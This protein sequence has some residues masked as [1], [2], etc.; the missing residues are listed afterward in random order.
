MVSQAD[1]DRLRQ[2]QA[3][4]R[5]LVERDLRAYLSTLDMS[6]VQIVRSRLL[7]FVPDLVETYGESAAAMAQDWY[8]NVRDDL[9]LPR[10]FR[11]VVPGKGFW[12]EAREATEGTVRRVAGMAEDGAQSQMATALSSKAGKYAVNASRETIVRSSNEDP[13]ASGW[14]R[15]TRG[16]TCRFCRMLAGRGAVC[17]DDTVR[18]AAHGGC[19]CA[20]VPSWDKNAPE[21]D[22]DLYKASAR[23]DGIRQSAAAGDEY[24]IREL[25]R[26]RALIDRAINEYT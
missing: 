24:A 13:R 2:G 18:F 5:A 23:M 14:R 17:K 3:G 8:E 20:A 25:A 10:H 6:N 16:E 21:V 11:A 19:N 4:I 15:V 12:A 22:V 7:K 26:Y 1:I 9:G